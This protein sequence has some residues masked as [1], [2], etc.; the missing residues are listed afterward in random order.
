MFL[1]LL[2][3]ALELTSQLV[4]ATT[5]NGDLAIIEF[6]PTSSESVVIENIGASSINL[7]N[8]I[9]QYFNKS[10]P[11]NFNIPTTSQQLPNFTLQPQ[12]SFLL[13]GDSA[14]T[15][16]A[17][18]VANLS[19]SLSDSSGYLEV[20]KVSGSAGNIDYTV[21]DKVNWT[22]TASGADITSVPSATVGPNAVWYRKLIDGSWNKYEIDTTPCNLF[23]NVV[24]SSGPSY[25]D[26]AN[27]SAAPSQVVTADSPSGVLIPASDQGLAP[28]QLTELLPNPA[29]PQSD[30]EDEFIELYNP[31]DSVFDL[32]G[33]KLEVGLTT[34][35]DYTLPAGTT[36]AAKSFK[37][38]Y[39]L[40]TNLAMSNS[41]GQA[42]LIDPLGNIISQ[43]DQYSTAKEGQSW[44]LANGRWYW[45]ST[46]TAGQA[47]SVVLAST[48]NTTTKKSTSPSI[49]TLSASSSPSP[50]TNAASSAAA[51]QPTKVH[52]WT[53]AVIAAAALLYAL[54]EYRNDIQNNLYRARR[55]AQARGNAGSIGAAS[56]VSRAKGRSW[57]R[58]NNTGKGNSPRAKK[59]KSGK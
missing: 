39:S 33:F 13:T 57:W 42:K 27:G 10:S 25:V 16:G 15:C 54:Y 18:G 52:S 53:I 47:N 51:T 30:D 49:K 31:N 35:H 11:A 59:P 44:A 23:V 38:F 34:L 55:Y 36:I 2:L 46:P 45:D 21:Q 50:S 48:S 12:Q 5:P 29:S 37:S 1:A 22:S 24:Q 3:I 9:L 56:I 41:S 17:S 43:S 32:S 8:Y 26:W 20:A 6:K 28:P 58:Q 14:G 4:Y 7:Q 40:D 19:I